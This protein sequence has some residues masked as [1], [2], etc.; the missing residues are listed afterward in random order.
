VIIIIITTTTT[1][2]ITTNIRTIA[3]LP[4]RM[5]FLLMHIARRSS[6]VSIETGSPSYM[7][8]QGVVRAH[9]SHDSYWNMQ[10]KWGNDVRS[11]SHNQEESQ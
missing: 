6:V 7:E 8:R 9:A 2:T 3:A 10:R 4:R 11:L 1:T 5:C